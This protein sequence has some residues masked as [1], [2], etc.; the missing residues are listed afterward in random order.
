MNENRHVQTGESKRLGDGA[1]VAEVRERD[2]DAGDPVGVLSEERR[3]R[4][5]FV[6]ALDRAVD[7]IVELQGDGVDA[8]LGERPKH[9]VA[10]GPSQVSGEEPPVA[11]QQGEC[12]AFDGRAA[13]GAPFG[14]GRVFRGELSAG[15]GFELVNAH[16]TV[17][18]RARASR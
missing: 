13:V 9:L 1:F 15:V 12:D 14:L 3:A 18:E 8:F 17:F 2:D 4:L 11:D 7:G 6:A 10:A 5:G 16:G